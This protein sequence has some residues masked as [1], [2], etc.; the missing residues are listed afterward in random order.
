MSR[1]SGSQ[2]TKIKPLAMTAQASQD[3]MSLM[4]SGWGFNFNH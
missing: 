2:N 4:F 1:R 3:V